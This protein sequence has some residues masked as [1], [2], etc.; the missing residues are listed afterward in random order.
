MNFA[1][2][3]KMNKLLFKPTYLTHKKITTPCQGRAIT[4]IYSVISGIS[5]TKL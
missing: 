1:E 4:V 3:G 2:N 5:P